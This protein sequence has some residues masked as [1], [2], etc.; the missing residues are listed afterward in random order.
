MLKCSIDLI[1]IARYLLSYLAA[2]RAKSV[3][4][5]FYLFRL[6]VQFRS[7]SWNWKHFLTIAI[8]LSS[9]KSW[10]K[11]IL[12]V[13]K[14]N[15]RIMWI[16]SSIFSFIYKSLG[17]SQLNCKFFESTGE[18]LEIHWLSKLSTNHNGALP[19]CNV[20]F[21]WLIVRKAGGPVLQFSRL[22]SKT[23]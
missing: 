23:V 8:S 2:W 9:L 18:P 19:G 7:S 21:D 5:S 14:T 16:S 12:S 1:F 13:I 11:Y 4:T 20:H 6:S 15:F 3:L 10:I 22:I 17:T